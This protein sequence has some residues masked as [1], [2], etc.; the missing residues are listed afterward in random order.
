MSKGVN[1]ELP[2]PGMLP[3]NPLY[4]FKVI[5]DGI[6]KLLINDE[7]TKARFSLKNAE[8]RIYAGKM[9]VEKGKD[10]LAV[11]IIA[12]GNNYLDDALVAIKKAKVNTPKNTDIKP[13]LSQFRTASMKFNEIYEGLK[14]S[15]D[16]RWKAQLL[17]EQ[18]RTEKTRN[19]VEELLRQK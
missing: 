5:R 16:Q 19:S 14:P 9:L 7:L 17:I 1:Y 15:I 11:E 4:I 12:K 6:V 13:F 8:K 3:D 10:K 18:Q 2:Y